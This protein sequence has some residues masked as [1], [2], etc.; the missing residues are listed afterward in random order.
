MRSTTTVSSRTGDSSTVNPEVRLHSDAD[1]LPTDKSDFDRAI[2]QLVKDDRVPSYLKTIAEIE[3]LKNALAN[4]REKCPTP[5]HTPAELSSYEAVK[6]PE[7]LAAFNEALHTQAFATGY[8]N[9]RWQLIRFWLL[10]FVT[11]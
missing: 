1:G 4:N 9:D 11:G 10:L 3:E 8:S 7:G 5:A 2:E 6:T